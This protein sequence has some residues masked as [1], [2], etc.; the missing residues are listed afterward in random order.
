MSRSRFRVVFILLVLIL[1]VASILFGLLTYWLSA[2]TL[3]DSAPGQGWIVPAEHRQSG[4][5]RAGQSRRE[6]LSKP[7]RRRDGG[8]FC[9]EVGI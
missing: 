6:I 2:E 3:P 8:A 7:L 1:L 9:Q 5:A 4:A